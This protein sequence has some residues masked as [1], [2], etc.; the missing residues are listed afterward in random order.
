M[1]N[2]A[3]HD[4]NGDAIP[5]DNS[6]DFITTFD[7]LHDMANPTPVIQ[8][9]RDALKP[10]RHLAGSRT[11][12]SM[13]TFEEN[14]EQNPLAPLMYGFSVMC[15]M[16]SAMSTPDGEGLGTLGFTEPVARQ[17]GRQRRLQPLQTPR[18]R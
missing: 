2:V 9:I 12:H 7:C 6:F 15:C 13:P 14:L 11:F 1:Q 18:F 8:A 10:G 5:T 17:D 16:S 3:F 4:A